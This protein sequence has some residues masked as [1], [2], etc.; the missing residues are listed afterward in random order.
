[1][2]Q[3]EL[4][5]VWGYQING[6]R[7]ETNGSRAGMGYQLGINWKSG[8][9][10]TGTGGSSR[11]RTLYCVGWVA[12]TRLPW[13]IGRA[14]ATVRLDVIPA[15]YRRRRRH[16]GS[17]SDRRWSRRAGPHSGQSRP[18]TSLPPGQSEA[19]P[20]QT[21]LATD[22]DDTRRH[23]HSIGPCSR[24]CVRHCTFNRHRGQTRTRASSSF[25]HDSACTSR[26]LDQHNL[27]LVYAWRSSA[28]S[29]TI[30]SSSL[31]FSPTRCSSIKSIW[32][33]RFQKSS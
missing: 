10:E 18:T 14:G 13:Q 27:L 5:L 7:L 17:H 11:R 16:C 20:V 32:P 30:P 31:S 21:Q 2:Y 25:P 3:Y 4:V 33:S 26:S 6:C 15:T 29:T 23:Q 19:A 12:G 22:H 1:M 24:E 9:Q 8:S 28:K